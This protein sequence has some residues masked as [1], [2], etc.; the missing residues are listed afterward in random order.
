MDVE[1]QPITKAKKEE[2]HFCHWS[3]EKL[4]KRWEARWVLSPIHEN[5]LRQ[6][7]EEEVKEEQPAT[8]NSPGSVSGFAGLGAEGQFFQPIPRG[9]YGT[10][11]EGGKNT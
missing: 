1:L 8:A 4:A 9:T 7:C 11:C 5:G 3:L 6:C 2:G 10:L